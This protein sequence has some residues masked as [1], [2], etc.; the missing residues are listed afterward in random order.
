M[1]DDVKN[2]FK[3]DPELIAEA[4]NALTSILKGDKVINLEA[5]EVKTFDI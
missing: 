1:A 4:K 2:Y 3:D 5:I